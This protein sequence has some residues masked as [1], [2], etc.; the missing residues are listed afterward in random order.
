MPGEDAE[1]STVEKRSAV[2]L[3]GQ[4]EDPPADLFVRLV[5][6]FEIFGPGYIK[7]LHTRMR[8]QGVS[9]ARMRLL[10]TLHWSE[11]AV[12]MSDLGVKLGVT[13][14]N[15]TKLVDALAEEGL[16]RRVPHPTDRRATLLEVTEEGARTAREEWA[17]HQRQA[18][19]LFAVLPESDCR[20]LL[21][22]VDRLNAEL[23]LR[24]MV[25][26]Q[27]LR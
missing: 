20:E 7:W 1:G 9:Y 2:D 18:G 26:E 12:I 17:E 24:G 15:I 5:E 14:R 8:D 4:G 21:R 11:D 13:P 23:H 22:L 10:G 16:L 19:A 6:R 3:E 25:G 27:A